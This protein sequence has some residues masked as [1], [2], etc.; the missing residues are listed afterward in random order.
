MVGE[1]RLVGATVALAYGKNPD[2]DGLKST[3]SWR[4][5]SARF[6]AGPNPEFAR[7]RGCDWRAWVVRSK[8]RFHGLFLYLPLDQSLCNPH[9]QFEQF[10]FGSVVHC[11]L[12]TGTNSL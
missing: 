1:G 11:R 4:G 6:E 5:R 8:S 3:L 12:L 9:K 2:K 7:S 10:L